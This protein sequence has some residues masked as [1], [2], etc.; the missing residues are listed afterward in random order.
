M[1][2]FFSPVMIDSNLFRTTE[3]STTDLDLSNDNFPSYLCS[4]VL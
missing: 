2:H 3:F 1:Y 4:V